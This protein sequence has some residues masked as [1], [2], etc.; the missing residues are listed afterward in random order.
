MLLLTPV[1]LRCL[2][3]L[4]VLLGPLASLRGRHSLY[5]GLEAPRSP[6]V[7]FPD[8]LYLADSW[9]VTPSVFELGSYAAGNYTATDLSKP[10]PVFHCTAP[11]VP[12]PA[13]HATVVVFVAGTVA[14]SDPSVAVKNDQQVWT[15]R[16]VPFLATVLGAFASMFILVTV[17]LPTDVYVMPSLITSPDSLWTFAST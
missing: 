6:A 5:A 4:T 3:A 12:P 17:S 2:L 15:Q 11:H 7:T 14:L 8:G 16:S 10:V 9:T 1:I 13:I